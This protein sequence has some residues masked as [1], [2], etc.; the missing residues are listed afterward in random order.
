MPPVQSMYGDVQLL[1]DDGSSLTAHSQYLQHAST[2]LRGALDCAK[3][4]EPATASSDGLHASDS[5]PGSSPASKRH[6]TQPTVPLPGV[7]MPQ[8]MLLLQ[9]LYSFARETFVWGLTAPQL[10]ELARVADKLGCLEVLQLVDATLVG[11]CAEQEK[12]ATTKH[13]TMPG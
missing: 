2:M 9:I 3:L 10:L 7:T 11:I 6:R 12:Q 1:L 5:S 4:A 8:A 13:A